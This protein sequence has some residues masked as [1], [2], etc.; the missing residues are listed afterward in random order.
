MTG[1]GAGARALVDAP[2]VLREYAFL[3]DG[4]RGALVGPRGDFAWLCFPRWHDPAVF[5]SLIG[6]AGVFAVSPRDRAVWGGYYEDGSLIWHSRWA[7]EDSIIECRE[8]LALPATPERT[9]VLRRIVAVSGPARVDARLGLRADFG[10]APARSVREV[11]GCWRARVGGAHALVL[12][13][14]DAQAGPDGHS[15]REIFASIDLEEGESHDIALILDAES[16]PAEPESV[17]ALW[18]GTRAAWAERVPRLSGLL[19]ERESRHAQA[20]L[21]GMTS[22]TGGMV[23]AATMSLPERSDE[24]RNYDYRYVW[25]R[26]GCY[27][28]QAAARAGALPLLD[29]AVRF[30]GERLREHGAK[31]RPAYTVTGG[32]LPREKRLDLPGYPGGSDV[33][34][35]WV[36]GQTQLDAFGESLL[37]LA[38]AARLDRLDADGWNA[39]NVAADAVGSLWREPDAGIW[40]L[41]PAFW[42]HGRLVCAA[43]LRALSEVATTSERAAD[44]LALADALVAEC[45]RR[46]VHPTGRWQRSPDDERIDAALLMPGIRGAVP[47]DDP[48]TVATLRAVEAELVQNGYAYRYRHDSRPLGEAEGAFL[49]CGFWMALALQQQG[50]R[51]EAARWFERS[52]AACGSPGLYSEEFDVLQRQLRGNLPQAFVHALLLEC[53]VALA[54]GDDPAGPLAAGR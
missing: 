2:H 38:A 54:G 14:A 16:A 41:D 22:E 9:I 30:V 25:I 1:P 39:A 43:G 10:R 20:V 37:L 21:T 4:E 48:R 3:G 52:R 15:G 23:A 33:V 35:N 53:A 51:V 5:A 45:A 28:G 46:C 42:A 17:D 26:D 11:D 49:V 13:L 44:W 47:A 6:G 40:E 31:L 32:E 19:A 29:S 36:R 18:D 12:G 34:G 8:A 27:A 7:A 50:E 24:G